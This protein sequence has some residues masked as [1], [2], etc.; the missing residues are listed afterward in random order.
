MR[1]IIVGGGEIGYALARALSSD[2]ALFVIDSDPRVAE[3]FD[4]LDVELLTGS[5]TSATL[6]ER[7]GVN[8][9]GLFIACTG[10]DE[11]NIVAC[12][13]SRQ[14][15][16]GRTICFVSRED[17]IHGADGRDSLSA[18]FGVDA[19]IWPEAQ[20]ADAIERI[21]MAP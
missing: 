1:I 21:I 20:L 14:L 16:G 13:L 7:A 8:G 4:L 3:R 2:H 9:S 12:A 19:V 5:G 18:R 11:V 10:L 6:L 17:F 15:G